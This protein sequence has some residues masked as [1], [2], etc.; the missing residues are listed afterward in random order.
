MLIATGISGCLSAQ[1]VYINGYCLVVSD[2]SIVYIP[3]HLETSGNNTQPLIDLDGKIILK[4]DIVNNSLSTVFAAVEPVP[5]GEL[6]LAGSNTQYIKG[7]NPIEFENLTIRNYLKKLQVNKCKVHGV[8]SIDAELDLNRNR[9]IIANSSALGIKYVSG[10]IK[11]ETNPY[12]GLSEIEWIVGDSAGN[13]SVPFGSG[14]DL[15]SSA[16]VRVKLNIHSSSNSSTGK[17]VFATYPTVTENNPLPDG[18]LSLPS[19]ASLIADRYWIV[20]ADY[21]KKPETS[22]EFNYTDD[23]IS[24]VYNPD[25]IKDSLKAYRYNS[26]Y[27]EWSDWNPVCTSDPLKNTVTTG[28]IDGK[29]LFPVWLLQ[30]PENHLSY[31]VPNAFTPNGDGLNDTFGPVFE[32]TPKTYKF[33]ILDRRKYDIFYTD[34]PDRQWDGYDDKNNIQRPGIYIWIMQATDEYGKEFNASGYVMLVK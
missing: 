8:L 34:N 13:Y 25:I 28:N 18:I 22:I 32:F 26:V 15:V 9:L 33:Y 24:S 20:D 30:N 6:I 3:G 2:S 19:R 27:Q 16:D 1:D 4:G 21:L 5:N 10:F 23:D 14:I 31:Y 7:I 17:V 12:E 29:N 11:S